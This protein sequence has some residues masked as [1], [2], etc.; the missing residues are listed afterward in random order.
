MPENGK[1]IASG[2]PPQLSSVA[3]VSI[4][5]S[6][7]KAPSTCTEQVPGSACSKSSTGRRRSPRLVSSISRGQESVSESNG[8]SSG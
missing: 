1:S 6:T 2:S 4:A 5:E 3:N 7:P 8:S